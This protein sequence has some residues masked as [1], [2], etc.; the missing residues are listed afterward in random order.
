MSSTDFWTGEIRKTALEDMEKGK[1]VKGC[2]SCYYNE[3]KNDISHR[4][5]Y[6]SYNDLPLKNLPTM[7]DLDFSNFCNL[8]CVMCDA[9]RSSQWAKD[10]G[11]PNNGISTVSQNF[12][13]NLIEISGE[14]TEIEIQGGEPS[15][16]KEYE[17]YFENLSKRNLT[18]NINLRIVTNVTNINKKFYALLETFKSVKLN[19]SIDAF[20]LANT[21]I[22][23]PSN[24]DQIEKNLIKMSD[25]NKVVSVEIF[26]SL[27]LLSLFNYGQFLN[28]CK[29]IEKIYEDKNQYFSVQVM[30]VTYPKKYNPFIAPHSLKEKF[31]DDVRSFFTN[32]RFKHNINFKTENSLIARRMLATQPDEDALQDLRNTVEHLDT[33]RNVKITN[34]IPDFYNYL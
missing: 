15:I 6:N 8:K 17:Y 28:W 14:V 10:E 2:D 29:K 19:V 27:N 26:N 24:F 33:K 11:A 16:M 9:S 13:D 34:Y 22:R 18:K 31:Q 1:H 32:N 7:L 5:L 30:K 23:W 25:L 3:S 4:N 20:G 12:I 21:Y